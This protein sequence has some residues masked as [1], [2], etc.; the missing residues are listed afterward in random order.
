[1]ATINTY[2][3]PL[4]YI[5]SAAGLETNSLVGNLLRLSSSVSAGATSLPV[6]PST[7]VQ[8]K[9]NDQITIFDQ[10]LS[11]VVLVTSDVATGA[12]SIPVTAISN[13]HESLS[14]VCS[15]GVMG[16]LSDAIVRA[17][18]WIENICQQSLY[19]QSYTSETLLIPSMRGAF[20][21][22][23]ML[24]IRPRHFPVESA[25]GLIIETNAMTPMTYD[26]SQMILDGAQQVVTVPFLASLAGGN[27]GYGGLFGGMGRM[28]RAASLYLKISYTAGYASSALPGD[29]ADVA[30]ML[31]SEI[32][33]RRQNPTGAAQL[34]LG[35]KQIVATSPRDLVGESLLVKMAK[36]KLQQ[37]S[38][39]VF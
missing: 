13:N 35:D 9:A 36:Q 14:I 18:N 5:R 26:A 32:I 15:D 3:D 10:D 25:T 11:E 8:L 20:D 37:Y 38:M 17:S 2:T 28:S 21:N 24:V 23:H 16:S 22:H 29:I 1:M 39:Q 34:R 19:Q 7:T 6:M 27:Q 4:A 12:T 31:T 30:I 33:G